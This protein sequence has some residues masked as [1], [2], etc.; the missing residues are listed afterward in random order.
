MFLDPISVADAGVG[1]HREQSRRFLCL[2][3]LRQRDTTHSQT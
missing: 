1:R 2:A 3:D